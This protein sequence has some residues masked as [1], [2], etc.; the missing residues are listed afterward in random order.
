MKQNKNALRYAAPEHKTDREIVLDAVKQNGD[1]LK[2]AAP[3]HKADREIVVEAVNR[4]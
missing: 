4:L 2:H 1:A 3:V